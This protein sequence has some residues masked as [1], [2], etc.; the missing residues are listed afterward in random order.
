MKRSKKFLVLALSLAF[1]AVW[2]APTVSWLAD[3]SGRVVNTFAGGAISIVL[4]ESPVD[5][6]GHKISGDRVTGNSYKYVAGA[7]LDKDP[8]P[9]VLKGSE[10]CYVFILVEN[11]LNELFELNIDS[12]SLKQVARSGSGTLYIYSSSVDASGSQ[13]DIMLAPIFTTVTVTAKAGARYA[14]VARGY[15]TTKIILKNCAVNGNV[16]VGSKALVEAYDTRINGTLNVAS[17]ATAVLENSSF[18]DTQGSGSV[19]NK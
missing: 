7:T 3:K 16:M 13:Q 2:A 18:T 11:G 10:P 15:D 5:T 14:V 8:A 17:Q 6:Q 9:T 12:Q 1:A 19:I 4:D